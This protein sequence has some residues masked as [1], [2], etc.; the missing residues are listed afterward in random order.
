MFVNTVTC[1]CGCVPCSAVGSASPTA[2]DLTI[3]G[4]ADAGTCANPTFCSLSNV[5]GTLAKISDC[6]YRKSPFATIVEGA[7]V[8]VALSIT[9]VVPGTVTFTLDITISDSTLS[10]G[11]GYSNVERYELSAASCEGTFVLA[12]TLTI[13]GGSGCYCTFPAT[14][15]IVSVP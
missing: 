14:V 1:C 6:N 3:A 2:Y 12:H 4:T 13:C 8:N 7:R 9:T 15:T 5:T 11:P 10:C